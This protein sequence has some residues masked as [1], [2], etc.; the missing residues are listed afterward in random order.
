MIKKIMISKLDMIRVP[1][2]FRPSVI[3]TNKTDSKP[4]ANIYFGRDMDVIIITARDKALNSDNQ[5]RINI[6]IGEDR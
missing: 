3:S 1:D 4:E 5:R 2:T 6:L